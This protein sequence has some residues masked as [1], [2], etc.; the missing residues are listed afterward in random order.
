MA[1]DSCRY[2][3]DKRLGQISEYQKHRSD[4]NVMSP[5]P[6]RYRKG[7][8][9]WKPSSQIK[10]RGKKERLGTAV[11]RAAGQDR[12]IRSPWSANLTSEAPK[13]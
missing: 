5:E 10:P 13:K 2:S 9:W 6:E 7:R 1:K 4:W 8:T 11:N 3:M 12:T